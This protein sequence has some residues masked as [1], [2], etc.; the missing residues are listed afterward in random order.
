M[1]CQPH[2]CGQPL[3]FDQRLVRRGDRLGSDAACSERALEGLL[4]RAPEAARGGDREVAQVGARAR[5]DVEEPAHAGLAEPGCEPRVERAQLAERDEPEP[6]PVLLGAGPHR[7][8]AVL[9]GGIG[10]G[11]Q[12]LLRRHVAERQTHEDRRVAVLQLLAHVARAPPRDVAGQHRRRGRRNAITRGGRR[13]RGRLEH[14]G[15]VAARADLR[16]LLLNRGAQ[17]VKRRSRS[18]YLRRA[19]CLF[20]R[21]RGRRT[22]SARPRQSAGCR[23]RA[24]TRSRTAAAWR[25]R[26]P[27]AHERA[28]AAGAVVGELRDEPD[29]VDRRL[30]AVARRARQRHIEPRK[31]AAFGCRRTARAPRR[32]GLTS[33]ACIQ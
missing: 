8:V 21:F 28:E 25:G 12:L 20:C 24:R 31:S 4:N 7:A 26:Q 27:A 6:Q 32:V 1:W 23:P 17:P 16:A 13:L 5:R 29:V 19:R 3:I 15:R 10:H 18:T 30:R 33:N 2:E 11:A 22:P 9:L 14:G